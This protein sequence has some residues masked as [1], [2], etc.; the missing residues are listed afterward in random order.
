M[1]ITFLTIE[2]FSERIKMSPAS[3]RRLIRLRRIFAV[4]P[5]G[6]KTSAYRISETELERLH[7]QGMCE[8]KDIESK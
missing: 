8:S 7:V 4:K 2:E 5:G 3:I 6:G 1:N